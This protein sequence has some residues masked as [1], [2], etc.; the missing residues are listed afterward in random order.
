MGEEPSFLRDLGD[1]TKKNSCKEK[2][3]KKNSC[4]EGKEKNLIKSLI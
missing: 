4:K 3:Y 2:W 1:K